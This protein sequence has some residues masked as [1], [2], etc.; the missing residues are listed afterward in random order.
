MSTRHG[1]GHDVTCHIMSNC[2]PD[3]GV[4]WP[5][6]MMEDCY[7]DCFDGRKGLL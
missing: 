2:P 3:M 4:D 1:G 6:A 5:T 7:E